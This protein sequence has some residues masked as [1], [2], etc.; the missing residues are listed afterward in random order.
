VIKDKL[1]FAAVYEGL[2]QVWAVP[3]SSTTLSAAQRASITNPLL[4]P[5]LAAFPVANNGATGVISVGQ[6]RIQEDFGH[7][8]F[9]YH[10]N[11]RFNVYARYN[12][13]Q[14]VSTQVQDASLSRF[15]QVSVPQNGVLA[16]N[17][18][19]SPRMFNETKFGYNGI[20]MRVQGIAG[21][22][23]NANLSSSRISIAGLTN[24]GSLISLSSS[25]NGVGA[26][27]TG[28]TYSFIDNF[29]Y[30]IGNHNTKVGVEIRPLSL[31]N[32]QIGGTTYT[33]NSFAKLPEQCSRPDP[34]LRQPQRS[35]P[36]YRP[37]RQ[38]KG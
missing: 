15:N 25:F 38:R 24:V 19:L 13:D 5:L 30:V 23:P 10:I 3:Y 36:L 2:R 17:Q 35:K 32:D 29:S 34:V 18:V 20:K 11:D 26:P 12:R 28:Q 9:D 21:A 22:S 16:L 7:I 1:F 4:Q 14:G 6:N 37:E 8:R 27:Y 33:Y 31:Y